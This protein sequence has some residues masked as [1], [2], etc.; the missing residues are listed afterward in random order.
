MNVSVVVQLLCH[1]LYSVLL[2]HLCCPLG[3]SK[4]IDYSLQS[5]T[6]YLK[7]EQRLQSIIQ[8]DTGSALPVVS[9]AASK[10]E[11]FFQILLTYCKNAF[12]F[13]LALRNALRYFP[14]SHHATLAPEFAQEL[15]QYGH[16]YMYRFCPTFRMRWETR[17]GQD[18][19]FHFRVKQNISPGNMITEMSAE[20]QYCIVIKRWQ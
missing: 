14:P 18:L 2:H 17:W 7:S 16:I 20:A 10:C 11:W 3:C 8:R 1:A 5:S 19:Y 13:Q 4:R 12:S 6:D 15:R 9:G